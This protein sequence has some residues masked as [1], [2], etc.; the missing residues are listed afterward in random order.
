MAPEY[1]VSGTSG[2]RYGNSSMHQSSQADSENPA[3]LASFRAFSLRVLV[4][5]HS[6][7]ATRPTP[8]AS[9]G[10]PRGRG[11]VFSGVVVCF[12]AVLSSACRQ[13]ILVRQRI[14][15]D[16]CCASPRRVLPAT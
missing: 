4:V 14:R 8:S 7:R 3:E 1:R 5:R 15:R 11:G 9:R 10:R 2:L 16:T 13:L 6:M 12:M